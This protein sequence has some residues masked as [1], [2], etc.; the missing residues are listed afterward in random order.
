M[1]E[2]FECAL[3]TPVEGLSI[4]SLDFGQGGTVEIDPRHIHPLTQKTNEFDQ[5]KDQ[6]DESHVNRLKS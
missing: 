2:R 6:I 1:F 3:I 4:K 5:L